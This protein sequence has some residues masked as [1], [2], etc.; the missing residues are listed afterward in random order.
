MNAIRLEV[1]ALPPGYRKF[2]GHVIFDVKMDFRCK[3]QWV[4]D[5]HTPLPETSS[6]AGVLSRVSVTIAFT[7]AA[8]MGLPV[9][10]GNIIR[11]AYL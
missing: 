2:S 10:A 7:S 8:V 9:K 1:G 11:N 4:Q 3:A 6:Y 5:G